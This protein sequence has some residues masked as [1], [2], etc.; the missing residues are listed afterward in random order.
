ME[1]QRGRLSPSSLA[2]LA[3]LAC[4]DRNRDLGRTSAGGLSGLRR[5]LGLSEPV[6]AN[7]LTVEHEAFVDSI[8][9]YCADRRGEQERL[10]A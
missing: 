10:L 4:S 9:Q 1:Q 6:A 8:Q 3:S 5:R 7:Y 2:D